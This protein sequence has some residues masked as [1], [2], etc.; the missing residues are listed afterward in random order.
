[1]HFC[2]EKNIITDIIHVADVKTKCST[3][4]AHFKNRAYYG[5]AFKLSGHATYS[6]NGRLVDSLPNTLIFLPRGLD[7]DVSYQEGGECIAVNFLIEG[8]PELEPFVLDTFAGDVLSEKFSKLLSSWQKCTYNFDY[9]CFSILYDI[10][11]FAQR[12]ILAKYSPSYKIAKLEC[13][14]KYIS[15]HFTEPSLNLLQIS[16]ACGISQVYI[17][18]LFSDVMHISPTS[19]ITFL[20][21]R[22]ARDLLASGESVSSTA[23]KAGYSDAF[24]FSKRFSKEVGM[25][26]SQY[27]AE[28]SLL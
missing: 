11:A 23:A 17:R 5:L 4:T 28:N 8:L 6:F 22:Y 27:R 21:I 1:M 18:K 19:Y 14:K 16:Q 25:P 3:P 7:Y 24:Y 26:P 10:M 2:D 20:R 13:A 9:K 12:A 15:E